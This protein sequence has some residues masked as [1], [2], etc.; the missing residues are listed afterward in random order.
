MRVYRIE[1][2]R[3]TGDYRNM[4]RRYYVGPF[5][6]SDRM[7]DDD[8]RSRMYNPPGPREWWHFDYSQLF[9]CPSI[10]ALREW[11]D[12]E[13]M[14]ELTRLGFMI[15]VYE[16]PNEHVA[17]CPRGEQCAFSIAH[18]KKIKRKTWKGDTTYKQLAA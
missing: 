8:A 12:D 6:L 18:A 16:V 1:H 4:G 13:I 2:K 3:I 9:A 11:F 15:A 5:A 7:Q 17:K 14:H 10:S